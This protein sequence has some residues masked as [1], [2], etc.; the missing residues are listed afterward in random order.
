MLSMGKGLKCLHFVQIKPHN[1][2]SCLLPTLRKKPF[3]NIAG[4]R[5]NAGYHQ[6]FS[7]FPTMF[8]TLSRTELV[9]CDAFIL[10]SASA[11]NLVKC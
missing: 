4:K 2:Q 1:T 7:P 10:S 5:E 6:H 11:F 9:I 8:S 3:E